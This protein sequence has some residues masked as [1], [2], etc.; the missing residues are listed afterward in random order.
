MKRIRPGQPVPLRVRLALLLGLC[1]GTTALFG[2]A[3]VVTAGL[4][5]EPARVEAEAQELAGTLAYA[6][7]VP[8]AFDDSKAAN[9]TLGMLRARSDVRSA[10][11]YDA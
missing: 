11:V 10:T 7:E 3:A 2:I 5:F 1:A 6:L 9:E 8:L 4:W